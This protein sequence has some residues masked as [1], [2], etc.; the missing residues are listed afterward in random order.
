MGLM[1][2]LRVVAIPVVFAAAMAYVLHPVVDFLA[3]RRIPRA[4]ASAI[5]MVLALVLVAFLLF[6]V[7]PGILGQLADLA[8]RLPAMLETLTQLITTA[9]ADHFSVHVKL[10]SE[11]I[12]QVVRTHAA[13]L[14][15]PGGWLV[16]NIFQSLLSVVLVAVNTVIAVVLTYYMIDSYHAIAERVIELIPPRFR[17]QARAIGDAVDHALSAFL[18]GQITVCIL[19]AC[20]YSLALTLIGVEGGAAIGI[21]TGLVNFVPYLGL[22]TGLSLSLLS[23]VLNNGEVWQFVAVIATFSALPLMDS[24]VITPKIVGNRT[25]LNPF[26]V[27]IALLIGAE[28]MGPLGLLLALPTA[29]VLRALLRL[30]LASYRRSRFYLGDDDAS[31]DKSE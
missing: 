4:V 31:P 17:D 29:A 15:A 24:T 1:Y 18:R 2:R 20:L 13:E 27:I 30:W 7:L 5:A 22:V 3:A 26:A 28:L 6:L 11:A 25:G 19:M 14:A 12:V 8:G 23:L 10:D 9:L 16:Q 21:L